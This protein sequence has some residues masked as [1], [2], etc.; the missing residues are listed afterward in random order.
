MV[1]EIVISDCKAWMQAANTLKKNQ[2]STI[3]YIIKFKNV[4]LLVQYLK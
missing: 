3:S 2:T 4:Q 1:F